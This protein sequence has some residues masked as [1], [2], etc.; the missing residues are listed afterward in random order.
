MNMDYNNLKIN[1]NRQKSLINHFIRSLFS[2]K[3]VLNNVPKYSYKEYLDVI[4]K[5]TL[6]NCSSLVDSIDSSA[7]LYPEEERK[8]ISFLKHYSL[9][10]LNK[11]E[12]VDIKDYLANHIAITC[13]LRLENNKDIINE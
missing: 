12:I 9:K 6:F 4:N 11:T 1:A 5:F 2:N 13:M 8:L 7:E 10:M 3:S